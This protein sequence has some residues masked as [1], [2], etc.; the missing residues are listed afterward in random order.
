[1]RDSSVVICYTEAM[2]DDANFIAQ[3]DPHGALGYVQQQPAQ[4][5]HNFAIATQ[6]LERPRAVVFAG[7]GGSVLAAEFARVAPAFSVPFVI[8]KS[9]HLPGWVDSSTLV[10]CGSYSGNTEET[11]AALDE[12][13]AKGAQIAV[14]AHGGA[15]FERARTAKHLLAEIPQCPQPRTSVFYAYRALVEILI[16]HQLADKALLAELETMIPRLEAATARWRSLTPEAENP[17]KQL[18]QEMLGKTLIIYGGDITAP[19]AWK[20]KISANENAKNT[21]WTGTYPEFNHNEIIGWSSHP[22]D[23]P[24]CVIDLLSSFEH[25]RIQKRFA[26]SDR[27]LSGMRPKAIPVHA[28]GESALE[29]LLYLV[30]LGDFATTYLAILNGVNPTPVALIEKFKKMLSE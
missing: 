11:I 20:W 14:I 12:A 18:A 29:Q 27:L 9:Y 23:K 1:M 2:L 7:M 8:V 30:L 25:E 26:V 4:L 24:F 17:A 19:A 6:Q 15:L 13:E 10:I 5:A 22:I 21:A 16:A 3:R 28:E